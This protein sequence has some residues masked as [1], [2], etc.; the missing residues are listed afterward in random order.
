MAAYVADHRRE[1]DGLIYPF[2][3]DWR[4]HIELALKQLIIETEELLDVESPAPF[5]HK[6]DELWTRL[7][8][9]LEAV[10]EPGPEQAELDNVGAVIVEVQRL[11]PFGD[12]FRYPL[13]RGSAPTLTDVDLLSFQAINDAFVPVANFLE[14]ARCAVS[15]WLDNKRDLEHE[16]GRD[17]E[18]ELAREYE[19]EIA[20]DAY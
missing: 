4:Q 11:D 17:Y 14:D 8:T 15:F 6:L 3:Y 12:A 19:Q 7:R 5:G 13:T 2:L 10:D 16:I 20:R 1:Q 9:A 18:D